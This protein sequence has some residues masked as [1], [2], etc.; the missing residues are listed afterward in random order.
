MSLNELL[1][2]LETGGQ[3]NDERASSRSEKLLNI[4]RDTGELLA[5]LIKAIRAETILEVG[6]SNGYSTL[7]LAS[8]CS[9]SGRVITLEVN[10]AKIELARRNYDRAGLAHKIDLRRI[11]ALDFFKQNR[12]EFDLVFLDAERVEYMN[13][14]A[15]A[16]AAVRP[17]GLLVCDNAVSHAAELADFI[18]YVE[19]G[20]RFTGCT[21]T[22]GKG[23]FIACKT[24]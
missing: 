15:E 11:D 21:A 16:V 2:E 1:A 18:G 10:P 3:I 14:A 4:T 9:D 7:W 20:G 13:F 17:G 12:Q 6:T 19:A 22:V 8:A 24:G 23:E 5:V